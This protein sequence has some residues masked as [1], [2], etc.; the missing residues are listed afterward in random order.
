MES[1]SRNF[2]VPRSS[3]PVKSNMFKKLDILIPLGRYPLTV[4]TGV[5]IPLGALNLKFTSLFKA[6]SVEEG[7]TMRKYL[8]DYNRILERE[9]ENLERSGCNTPNEVNNQFSSNNPMKNFIA[10]NERV[11]SLQTRIRELENEVSELRVKV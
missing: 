5:Q 9:L 6:I 4:A 2:V 1:V 8:H 10:L 7:R 11:D 3:S